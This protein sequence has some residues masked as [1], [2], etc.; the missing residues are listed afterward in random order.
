MGI[1][2][3]ACGEADM[4]EVQRVCRLP[5]TDTGKTGGNLWYNLLTLFLLYGRIA[6]LA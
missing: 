5:S 2:P 4:K 3:G 6:K 1:S